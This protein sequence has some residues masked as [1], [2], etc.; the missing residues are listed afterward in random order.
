M[1]H[2]GINE[3]PRV[4]LVPIQFVQLG[5]DI[6]ETPRVYLVPIQFVQLGPNSLNQSQLKP[7]CSYSAVVQLEPNLCYFRES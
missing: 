5:E 7:F 1:Y 4:Y 2:E 6:N 3:K